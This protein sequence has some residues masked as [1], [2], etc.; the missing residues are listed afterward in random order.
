MPRGIIYIARNNY[1]TQNHYKIGKSERADPTH[2]MRELSSDSTNYEGEFE[3]KGYV[4]VDDV[5]VCEKIVHENL[6]R[7]RINQRRE[8][9]NIDLN[10]AIKIIRLLLKDKIIEDQFPNN[11]MKNLNTLRNGDYEGYKSSNHILNF[12]QA[13]EIADLNFYDIC[14]FADF[15]QWGWNLACHG[16]GC[17]TTLNHAFFI[18]INKE[19]LIVKYLEDPDFTPDLD[20]TTLQPRNINQ[21]DALKLQKFIL[22]INLK[23]YLL[24]IKFPNNLGYL[25]V[26]LNMVGEDFEMENRILTKFLITNFRILFPT[27]YNLI[28][29]LDHIYYSNKII[30]WKDL[31]I[32]EEMIKNS[33]ERKFLHKY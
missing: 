14:K 26:V 17:L 19:K 22:E 21:D 20:Q 29:K 24:D 7:V 30:N 5:D 4:L 18:L 8:F 9:F 13:N 23:K 33:N 16:G 11:E 31:E 28:K 3:H 25:G 32:F 27:Q 12:V 10:E 15:H 1:N 6:Q 2:R